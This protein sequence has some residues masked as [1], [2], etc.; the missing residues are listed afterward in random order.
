MATDD[1]LAVL[2]AQNADLFATYEEWA[3]AQIML[4]TGTIDDPE[5]FDADGGK[6]GALGYYPVVNVSG[7]TLYV[8]CLARL[9]AIALGGANA[10]TLAELTQAVAGKIAGIDAAITELGE[11]TSQKVAEVDDAIAASSA[12]RTLTVQATGAATVATAAAQQK[13]DQ[14]GDISLAR[15]QAVGAADTSSRTA[16]SINAKLTTISD[17]S[18]YAGGWQTPSGLM[19]LGFR[20]TDLRPIFGNGG[21]V[22]GRIEA[23]EVTLAANL[24]GIQAAGQG[25][26]LVNAPRS[27]IAFAVRF[28]DG[29]MP[30][31]VDSIKGR[32]FANGRYVAGELDALATGLATVQGRLSNPIVD[33]PTLDIWALGN[34]LTA[35]A[36]T[37]PGKLAARQGVAVANTG[38]GGIGARQIA[39]LN[40]G[41][42]AMT[43]SAFTIPADTSAT[44]VT[45]NGWTPVSRGA[46][47]SVTIAGVQG[48]LARDTSGNHTFARGSAGAAVL[49]P[50]ASQVVPVEAQAYRNR[51]FIMEIARNSFRTGTA[52]PMS[53]A[54]LVAATRSLI[55]LQT[56]R[57]RRVIVWST[58]PATDEGSGTPGRAPL[59]ACNAAMAAA[60]PEHWLDL[61]G[62][63]RTTADTTV[64]TT[65]ITNPFTVA[66]I[67]PTSQD[68]AD[69]A[70]GL[71]PT[72]FRGD[73][74]HFNE[75]AGIAVAYRFD[76]EMQL[77]GWR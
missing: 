60:F 65:T 50:T 25:L 2:L 68:L 39:A 45:L 30:W 48:V 27:G 56:T 66:G 29:S 24:P 44:A 59:D 23:A 75:A 37:W 15:D 62:Y 58:P 72:S 8:A 35:T 61:A 46:S 55:D 71:T 3:N 11:T 54:Q 26:L 43:T 1:Q 21:D 33:F 32:F 36:G 69:I 47:Q 67:S 74:L 10:D 76:I 41:T 53:A 57:V 7:Q 38:I 64:G 34:S 49:V 20:I 73:N 6:V 17:R 51:I 5:S 22:V 12:A 28:P 77:R 42:P 40:G 31:H 4:L 13:A 63:L 9:R 19:G 52:D 70:N 14:I 18:G 16:I